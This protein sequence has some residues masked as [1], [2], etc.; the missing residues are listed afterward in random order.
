MKY[1]ALIFGCATLLRLIT[2]TQPVLS[3]EMNGWMQKCRSFKGSFEEGIIH[4]RKISRPLKASKS[5]EFFKND[6]EKL[7][8]QWS[9]VRESGSRS[10]T[11]FSTG[12]IPPMG[13]L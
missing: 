7:Q 2:L 1:A 3:E 12:A 5:T 8:Q 6:L 10:L 11:S 9:P 4:F 13:R